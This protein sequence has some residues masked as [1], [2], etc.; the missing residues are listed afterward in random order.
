[1][2]KRACATCRTETAHS[3]DRSFGVAVCKVCGAGTP[4]EGPRRPPLALWF[5]MASGVVVLA[6][7]ALPWGQIGSPFGTRDV[8][9]LSSVGVA[10]LAAGALAILS[11]GVSLLL[12]RVWRAAFS[13]LFLAG[14][15]IWRLAAGADGLSERGPGIVL[16][17][18][19]CIAIAI[20]AM[21]LFP[22]VGRRWRGEA[23][24]A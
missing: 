8:V 6:S 10:A 11:A 22:H 13:T 2:A 20:A 17:G 15:G 19:G 1:M 23:Q 9:A 16:A 14:L 3:E 12:G 4:I 18:A 7:A 24:T 21:A 5:L